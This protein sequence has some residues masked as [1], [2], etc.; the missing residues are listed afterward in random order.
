MPADKTVKASAPMFDRLRPQLPALHK[1]GERIA[2]FK[3]GPAGIARIPRLDRAL[4]YYRAGAYAAAL[5]D[6]GAITGK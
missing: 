6:T 5:A 1:L 3:P 2:A 4:I